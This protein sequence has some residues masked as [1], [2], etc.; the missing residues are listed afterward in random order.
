MPLYH[1][2]SGATA[3]QPPGGPQSCKQGDC[4]HSRNIR[5]PPPLLPPG[6]GRKKEGRAGAGSGDPRPGRWD[7]PAGGAAQGR[8][9]AAGI[10]WWATGSP[11]C[12]VVSEAEAVGSPCPRL[13]REAG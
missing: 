8:R 7:F 11:W 4:D 1:H 10:P 3:P 13:D 6:Q 9:P 12:L 5:S 2:S